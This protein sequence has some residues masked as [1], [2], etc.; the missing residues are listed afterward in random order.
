VTLLSGD[1]VTA[2][3]FTP[4]SNAAT[5][6]VAGKSLTLNGGS[7]TLAS[8]DLTDTADVV[9]VNANQT[10][11][12]AQRPS[13]GTLSLVSNVATPDFDAA[14]DFVLTLACACTLDNP[15][16][17]PVV[18]QAGTITL[19]QD[20]AGGRT[21]PTWGSYYKFPGGNKPTLTST[22]GH[23]DVLS[24]KVTAAGEITIT[25]AAMDPQ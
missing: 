24:Y 3:G 5:A 6:T 11:T 17:T 22:A 2:L 10:F 16:T 19:R 25:P 1:V 23:Y 20:G 8:T 7:I 14:S 4:L 13:V 18:G 12:K 21:V 15:S 9:R